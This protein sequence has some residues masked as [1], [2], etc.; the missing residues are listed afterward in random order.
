M[1]ISYAITV[2]QEAFHQHQYKTELFVPVLLLLFVAIFTEHWMR[3]K[4]EITL[5]TQI[6]QYRTVLN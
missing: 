3:R 2:L 1:P 4:N 6:D 5:Q